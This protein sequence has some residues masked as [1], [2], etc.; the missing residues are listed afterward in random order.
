MLA[1]TWRAALL[2]L[3]I[4]VLSPAQAAD[5]LRVAKPAAIGFG[6]SMLDV[7]I[8]AGIFKKHDLDVESLVLE[9]AAKQHQA[10]MAHAIDISLGAG[11][12]LAFLVKGSPEKGVA[13]L[14]GPPLAFVAMTRSDGK[15]TTLADMKGK[16]IAASTVGSLTYWL[17]TQISVSQHWTGADAVTVVPLGNFDAMRAAL[18]TGNID[19]ISATLEGA[20]L[21]EKAGSGKLLVK[22]GD[23]VHPFLTHML[24][25]SDDLITSNP[26]ALRRL[27]AGWFETVAWMKAHKDEGIRYS[28]EATKLPADVSS[29]AYDAEMTMFFT[30]GH[31]DPKDVAAVEH[32]LIES[33]QLDTMPD[34]SKYLTEEFLK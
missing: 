33:G 10:M 31:F 7:G 15:I 23:I 22:F 30:D 16:R 26:S 12:D 5:H 28:M 25:A 3:L 13:A 21:L 20:L 6:F 9:G 29:K 11:T 18:A 32:A 2:V 27:I 8:S 17:A 4:G 1:K 14:A 19:A 24:L 34:T